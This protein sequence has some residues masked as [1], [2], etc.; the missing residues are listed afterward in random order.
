MKVTEKTIQKMELEEK[1]KFLLGQAYDLIWAMQNK[2]LIDYY[3]DWNVN[4]DKLID[5]C[6]KAMMAISEVALHF[7]T[8]NDFATW[9]KEQ[10]N[11]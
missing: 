5:D 8:E 2:L 3:A 6:D 1:D 7:T 10:K 9:G 4:S 11:D